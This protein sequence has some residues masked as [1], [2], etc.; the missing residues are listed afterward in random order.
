MFHN[1]SLFVLL[2]APNVMKNYIP[3]DGLKEH[4]WTL[5]GKGLRG[6]YRYPNELTP[7]YTIN[8]IIHAGFLFRTKHFNTSNT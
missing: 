3:P 1:Y 8:T 2:L 7:T 5:G 4:N 6:M